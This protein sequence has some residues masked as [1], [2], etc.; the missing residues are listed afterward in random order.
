MS[1]KKSTLVIGVSTKPQ[2]YAYMA[3][4]SLREHDHP[5]IAYGQRPGTVADVD[6]ETEWDPA[7]KVDTVTLYLNP[8]NLEPYRGRIIAL[9]PKRVIFNP[10]TEHPDFMYQLRQHGIVAEAACT[11]VLLS[12]NQY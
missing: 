7:W 4:V 8:M 10:G 3:V 6:I 5:V 9:K 1:A 12:I 11:L 2:R